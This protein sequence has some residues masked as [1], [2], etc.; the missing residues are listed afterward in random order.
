MKLQP[1]SRREVKRIAIG[2]AVCSVI[3]TAGLFLL[4]RV[5][6]GSF[7]LGRVL[8]SAAAGSSIAVL[9]FALLCLTIQ[10]NLGIEDQKRM[11]VRFQISYN[12][13]ILFQAAWAAAALLLPQIHVVAGTAPLLFPHGVILYLQV[14]GRLHSQENERQSPE[15]PENNPI[16][17]IS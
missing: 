6:I 17:K 15:I 12:F 13:R 2:T 4:S 1:A 10:N 16:R 14:T 5:G 7:E 11:K 3:L 9:N 8:L